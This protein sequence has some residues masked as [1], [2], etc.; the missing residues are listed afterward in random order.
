MWKA[1]PAVYIGP[2]VLSL[3]LWE[4]ARDLM[5]PRDPFRQDPRHSG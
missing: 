3:D 5:S 2:F 1:D 4:R